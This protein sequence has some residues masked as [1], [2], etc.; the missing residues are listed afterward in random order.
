MGQSCRW[1]WDEWLIRR[2]TLT[3]GMVRPGRL[4]FYP[5]PPTW[6]APLPEAQAP[7]PIWDL[8]PPCLK[9]EG[10]KPRQ[11]V[12]AKVRSP[13][14]CDGETALSYK[15]TEMEAKGNKGNKE[16]DGLLPRKRARRE[17]RDRQVL[18]WGEG[19]KEVEAGRPKLEVR[20]RPR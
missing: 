16:E 7:T 13:H 20:P 10:V 11:K 19:G 17:K 15:E 8:H 5:S 3:F 1:G 14:L 18:E 4:S 12:R 2:Q 9:P 6:T